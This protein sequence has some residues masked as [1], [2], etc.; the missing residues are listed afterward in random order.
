MNEQ[1][2]TQVSTQQVHVLQV[3]GVTPGVCRWAWQIPEMHSRPRRA[4]C[5]DESVV[6]TDVFL[7]Q[8]VGVAPGAVLV[9]AL[10]VAPL[11]SSLPLP[12]Q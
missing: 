6:R 2:W 1:R 10:S 9:S 4:V 7:S 3:G 11:G 5:A 8:L 12:V